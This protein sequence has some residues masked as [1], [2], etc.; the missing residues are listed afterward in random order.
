MDL[1][2]HLFEAALKNLKNAVD[3]PQAL[4]FL[5][6][7]RTE[8][9]NWDNVKKTLKYVKL[10]HEDKILTAPQAQTLAKDLFTDTTTK[11]PVVDSMTTANHHEEIVELVR[12]FK[13]ILGNDFTDIHTLVVGKQATHTTEQANHNH[14]ATE[15][16]FTKIN[17]FFG[18]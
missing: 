5:N 3:G 17:K 16:H 2:S 14:T 13:K 6:D 15:E 1:Q 18:R 8:T 9:M 12:D 7:M 11:V 4:G 10:C